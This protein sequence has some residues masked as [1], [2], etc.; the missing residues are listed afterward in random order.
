MA[1]P[2]VLVRAALV[3]LTLYARR[4]QTPAGGKPQVEAV[5]G[6]AAHPADIIGTHTSNW[7]EKWLA[8][9]PRCALDGLLN[10]LLIGS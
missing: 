4:R 3:A 2:V 7:A 6:D 9:G 8:N 10:G 1:Y 5:A